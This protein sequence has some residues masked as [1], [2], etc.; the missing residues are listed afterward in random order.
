MTADKAAVVDFIQAET[1]GL[2]DDED[3]EWL[4]EGM[5]PGS[6][7]AALAIENIWAA[8]LASKIHAEGG[9]VA[10]THRVPADVIDEAFAALS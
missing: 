10:F 6:A 7:V 4:C 3:V 9:E 1:I 8:A 5:V 2:F